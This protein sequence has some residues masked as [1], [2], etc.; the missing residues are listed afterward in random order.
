MGPNTTGHSCNE[1]RSPCGSLRTRLMTGSRQA[2]RQRKARLEETSSGRRAIWRDRRRA[3]SG[4]DD[5][6]WP[7]RVFRD[8]PVISRPTTRGVG[9]IACSCTNACRT[10]TEPEVASM[11]LERQRPRQPGARRDRENPATR[12]VACARGAALAA[13]EIGLRSSTSSSRPDPGSRRP[14]PCQRWCTNEAADQS[15]S[16]S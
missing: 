1:A 14:H 15:P 12:R 6:A 5:G 9:A 4:P 7:A 10:E 3:L 8:L 13:K 16:L 2:R 11:G